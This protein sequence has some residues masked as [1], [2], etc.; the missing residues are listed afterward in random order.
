MKQGNAV[1]ARYLPAVKKLPLWKRILKH[2]A[3]YLFILPAFVWF[4]I[5]CYYPMYGLLLAFKDYKFSRG[6]LGSAWVGL[7]W[8]RRFS[9][10][11]A[12]WNVVRNTLKISVMK[13]M[14][15][16]PVPI[17]LALMMNAVP[18]GAYKRI[19]QTVSYMPH[20]I[21]WVVVAAMLQK[22]FSP[23]GG[24]VNSVRQAID[25]GAVAVHYLG[26]GRYFYWF[27]I[28]SDIWKGC[29]WG[30]IIYLASLSGIDP[31]L[32]EAATI[33]GARPM[34]MIV[35]ITLPLLYPTIALMLI[36]NLGNILNVGYEQLLQIQT[37]QTQHLAEVI[38]TYVIRT[39]LTSGSHSYATAIGLMKSAITLV[40]V[41]AVN[42][43]SDRLTGIS[44]F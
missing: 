39:G 24:L 40:L 3:I 1:P 2:R 35:R 19:V 14:L 9:F 4:L 10:D 27:V 16:F 20:F 7:K 32:Y 13:L 28:L 43:I 31:A 29:G 37:S 25:P 21:S 42:K 11:P 18:N 33:D 26:E 36:M 38:D 34:Q 23:Y 8:F 41:V 44:L 30:T 22:L 17:I 12:F 15:T 6:I 5:F